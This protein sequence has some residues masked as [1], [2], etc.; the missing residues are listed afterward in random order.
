[1]SQKRERRDV[2]SLESGIFFGQSI[3]KH[4]ICVQG[5]R[6]S[7]NLMV[8]FVAPNAPTGWQLFFLFYS[9]K[10][11]SHPRLSQT[12]TL[13][14]SHSGTKLDKIFFCL[15]SS[16]Q[17]LKQ[18]RARMRHNLT[19]FLFNLPPRSLGVFID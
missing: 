13:A 19:Y 18:T 15:V 12:I 6:A 1:M 5:I 16:S 8:A 17:A 2:D 9:E 4:G 10:N 14:N 11:L 7:I 3:Y